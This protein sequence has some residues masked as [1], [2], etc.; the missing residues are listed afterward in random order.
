MR[1]LRQRAWDVRQ[2][3]AAGNGQDARRQNEVDI[4]SYAGMCT[5]NNILQCADNL[6]WSP[7]G[8]SVHSYA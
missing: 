7:H 5:R 1:A 2:A 3:S 8:T 6:V 4:C